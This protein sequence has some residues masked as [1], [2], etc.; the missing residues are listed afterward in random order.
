MLNIRQRGAS[1]A[2]YL[3]YG[4]GDDGHFVNFEGFVAADDGEAV[5]TATVA[6]SSFGAASVSSFGCN[7]RRNNQKFNCPQGLLR[8]SVR[9]WKNRIAL[10]R[11]RH[12][13]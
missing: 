8:H 12:A 9:A 6:T 5:A 11:S 1:V 13:A 2:K 10:N 3:A 4:V 7:A